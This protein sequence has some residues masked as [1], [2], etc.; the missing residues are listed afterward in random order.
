MMI[1]IGIVITPSLR[2]RKRAAAD[3]WHSPLLII[4]AQSIQDDNN[5]ARKKT[6]MVFSVKN[7]KRNE[8]WS[9]FFPK[10]FSRFFMKNQ[11]L[12]FLVLSVKKNHF[13]QKMFV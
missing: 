10:K 8:E 6:V 11:K 3:S 13:L 5:Q 7:F 2:R 4:T 9:L 1:I 12:N